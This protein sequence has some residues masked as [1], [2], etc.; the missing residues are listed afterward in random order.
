MPL[1]ELLPNPDMHDDWR[2]YA[3]ALVAAL[4]NMNNLAQ[5]SE[6]VQNTVETTPISPGQLPSHPAGYVP[7]WLS[8]SDS[9]L[10]LGNVE[11]DPPTAP[12]LVHIDTQNLAVAAVELGNIADG[13]VS[14]AKI[15]DAAILTAKIAEAAI[16]TA[17]IGDL[18]VVT[19]KIS[20]LAVNNAKIANL[21]VDSAKIANLAVGTAH[22]QALAVNTGHIQDAAIVNAKIGN[23]IQSDSWND[24]NKAGWRIRKDGVIEGQGLALYNTSGQLLFG[25]GG[26]FGTVDY[27][28]QVLGR[29]VGTSF[30]LPWNYNSEAEF[31]KIW[32]DL[33]GVGDITYGLTDA[34]VIGGRYVRIGNNSG[35]DQRIFFAKE[36]IVF[37][38]SKTYEVLAMVRR[39]AGTGGFLL[40]AQGFAADRA[41]PVDYQGNPF[42]ANGIWYGDNTTPPLG[43]WT[44]VKGYIRGTKPVGTGN[45]AAPDIFNPGFAQSNTRYITPMVWVNYANVPGI[46]DIAWASLEPVEEPFAVGARNQVKQAD[47]AVAGFSGIEVEPRAVNGYRY[48]LNYPSVAVVMPTRA[49][50]PNTTYTLSFWAETV[51]GPGG[52][53]TADLFPDDLPEMPTFVVST[54]A[55]HYSWTFNSGTSGNLAAAYARMFRVA[56]DT[57]GSI[58]LWNI[59]FEE[60]NVATDWSPAPADLGYGVN[61]GTNSYGFGT[62]AAVNQVTSAN[63][64]ALLAAA[65]IGGTYIANA[66]I[67]NA[68]IQ[69]AVIT[70]A[71]IA[72]ATINSAKIANLVVDKL[73]SGQLDAVIDVGTGILRFTIGSARLSIGRGFGTTGQFVMWF[74]PAIAESLMSEGNATFYLKTNGSAY[75]GGSLSAGNLHNSARSSS[76]GATADIEIGPFGSNGNGRHY[77]A[78]WV[79]NRRDLITSDGSYSG[80]ASAMLYIDKMVGG[81]WSN[82]ASQLVSGTSYPGGVI[83]AGNE[84]TVIGEGSFTFTDSSGGTSVEK[85][86]ARMD[87]R[88]LPSFSGGR[89]TLT[90]SQLTGIASTEA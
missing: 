8:P 81:V 47:L 87:T 51:G 73:M 49:F 35:D 1:Q 69:D 43:E 38:P 40:G 10:W 65:S 88:T 80:T 23:V 59:Q 83:P 61:E 16:L 44:I 25:S 5:S 57:S 39:V 86:R 6:N 67:G 63:I 71:K 79:Y 42:F 75:F 4:D 32:Q 37:D 70:N 33:A 78:S 82:L 56:G 27:Y 58:R 60:G 64:A 26:Y 72:D 15:L 66:A 18:Q 13:A 90:E 12:D 21:A 52:T 68:H 22:I 41:T 74:G 77:V 48:L 36:P 84:A 7:V 76:L 50:T 3:R 45:L 14:T 55:Q 62:F 24:A 53:L 20:D 19:A 11:F 28:S 46:Y 30:L 29:P 2:S 89:S 9:Q 17:L 85:L 31:V 54:T 34:N